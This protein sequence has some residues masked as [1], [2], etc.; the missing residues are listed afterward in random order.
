MMGRKVF[1]WE[2]ICG[3]GLAKRQDIKDRR[4]NEQKKDLD[5]L[6]D[7]ENIPGNQKNA[8]DMKKKIRKV[9]PKKFQLQRAP[10]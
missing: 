6:E 3:K 1:I 10:R 5:S 4:K 9:S 2:K 8:V 7:K